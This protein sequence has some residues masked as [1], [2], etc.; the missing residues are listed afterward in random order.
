[1]LGAAHRERV[2][3]D[4]PL[5][6]GGPVPTDTLLGLFHEAVDGVESTEVAPGLWLSSSADVLS[7]PLASARVRGRRG[8][9]VFGYAGWGPGQLER[10]MQEGAWLALPND[11]ELAFAPCVDDLLAALLRPPG[12]Q[13]SHAHQPHRSQAL[14]LGRAGPPRF[15]RLSPRRGAPDS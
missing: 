8:R 3:A 9:L 6:V 12:H 11:K 10:E 1:M 7:P 5:H 15:P 4:T 13:P 14:G 2:H